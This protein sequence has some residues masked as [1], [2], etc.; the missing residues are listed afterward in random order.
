[1]NTQE[2]NDTREK[3]PITF[4]FLNSTLLSK[5]APR[6]STTVERS[7]ELFEKD[8]ETF[9]PSDVFNSYLFQ[10]ESRVGNYL[11]SLAFYRDLYELDPK[12]QN[13]YFFIDSYSGKLIL[14]NLVDQPPVPVDALELLHFSNFIKKL[15]NQEGTILVKFSKNDV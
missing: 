15:A 14:Q 12:E 10:E 7:I 6:E 1:M 5:D 9:S 13:C 11:L 3:T 2:A 4:Y 8:A